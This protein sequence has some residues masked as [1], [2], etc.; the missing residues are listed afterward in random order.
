MFFGLTVSVIAYF[1]PL[2]H[3]VR[4]LH[5]VEVSVGDIK[6]LLVNA[7]PCF[8]LGDGVWRGSPFYSIVLGGL[9][10]TTKNPGP[11]FPLT[12]LCMSLFLGWTPEV[13]V[14]RGSLH[15]CF[16]LYQYI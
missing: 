2:G 13:W 3:S 16:I 15:W 9:E 14:F 4:P 12:L 6:S 10:S 1:S 11:I 5:K 8:N 7:R